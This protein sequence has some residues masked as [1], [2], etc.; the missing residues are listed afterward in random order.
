M[1][2]YP[3]FMSEETFL[4]LLSWPCK[5]IGP[6]VPQTSESYQIITF[7]APSTQ[8]HSSFLTTSFY[9]L[10]NTHAH[11]S[12]RPLSSNTFP[13]AL[14][15]RRENFRKRTQFAGWA[16]PLWISGGNDIALLMALC[17]SPVRL[18]ERLC[19]KEKVLCSF[20]AIVI[21]S[22]RRQVLHF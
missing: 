20:A 21:R 4:S 1:L 10:R 22:S 16:K 5:M 2:H 14:E 9:F 18:G 13:G 19:I 15:N 3:W 12:F 8:T 6:T 11:D 7:G 17:I